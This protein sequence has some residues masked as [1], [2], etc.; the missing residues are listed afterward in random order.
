MCAT[1]FAVCEAVVTFVVARVLQLIT[2]GIAV[3]L[4]I[5]LWP[6][7]FV[8]SLLFGVRPGDLSTFLAAAFLLTAVGCVATWLPARR[9]ALV[10][11]MIALRAE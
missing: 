6:T 8:A 4:V 10:D 3:G 1:R 11:P 2:L 7:R 9:A 5:S